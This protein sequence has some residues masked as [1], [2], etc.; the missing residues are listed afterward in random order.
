MASSSDPQAWA[1]PPVPVQTAAPAQARLFPPDKC[2]RALAFSSSLLRP[3]LTPP[4][5]ARYVAAQAQFVY[6]GIVS[7]LPM[8]A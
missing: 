6:Y 1:T 2:V 5:P 7:R 3:S 4:R 8:V